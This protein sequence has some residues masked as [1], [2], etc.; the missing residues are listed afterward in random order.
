MGPGPNLKRSDAVGPGPNLRCEEASSPVRRAGALTFRTNNR[1]VFADASPIQGKGL[2]ARVEIPVD[3]EI[4]EYEGPRVPY[5]TGKQMTEEGNVYVF[6]VN[7][8][9]FLDGSVAWNLARHANH[10][11][12]PNAQAVS[13]DGRIWLRGIRTIA[14]GEEI[15]YDYG[16]SFRDEPTS[17]RC[18][19]PHC[20]GVIVAARHRDRKR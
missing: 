2:F 6:Q 3:T 4:V 17:C 20:V 13:L 11:C 1:R 19:A 5:K 16:Y 9:E 14:K 8:R 12:A 15:T 18:G 10:S 7:R